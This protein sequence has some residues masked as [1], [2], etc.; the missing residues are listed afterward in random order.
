MPRIEMPDRLAI[1][2]LQP[3]LCLFPCPFV[4]PDWPKPYRHKAN[5]AIYHT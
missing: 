5:L 1:K 2:G 3:I 4:E